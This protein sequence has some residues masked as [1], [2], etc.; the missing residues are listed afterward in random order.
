MVER[1]GT[2]PEEAFV[3]VDRIIM[4]TWPP[5]RPIAFDCF[6]VSYHAVGPIRSWVG[7]EGVPTIGWVGLGGAELFRA[8]HDTYS[9]VFSGRAS[10]D[11]LNAH[12]WITLATLQ[13]VDLTF[14]SSIR[15]VR[16][17]WNVPEGA[18]IIRR[19]D[20][21]VG[22]LTYHPMVVGIRAVEVFDEAARRRA[23]GS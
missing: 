14:A 17:G 6:A 4:E 18:T 7:C 2:I 19:P 22:G 1:P 11:R 5:G 12:C 3:G 10:A 21:M 23:S 9:D 13:V 8:D 15:E 20:E 16:P